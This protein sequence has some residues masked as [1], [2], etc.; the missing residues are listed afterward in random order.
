MGLETI[1]IGALIAGTTASIGT[2]VYSAAQE[3]KNTKSLIAAQEKAVADAE[4]KAKAAKS[5]ASQEAAETLKKQRLAQTQTILT[6][7]LGISD[8]ATTAK[9]TLG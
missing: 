3:K 2:S 7:P 9:T 8:E 6:T 5:L 4:A 1:L